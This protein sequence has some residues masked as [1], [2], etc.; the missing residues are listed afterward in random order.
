M[1]GNKIYNRI[2][3]AIKEQIRAA[4]VEFDS[5]VKVLEQKLEEDITNLEEKIVNNF[6]KKIL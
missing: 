5:E 2:L 3:Q 6:L 4:Q 1:F